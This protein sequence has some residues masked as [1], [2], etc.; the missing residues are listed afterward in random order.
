MDEKKR[1]SHSDS[2]RSQ[3]A[4][5]PTRL[6][7]NVPM[8]S[9][10]APELNGIDANAIESSRNRLS[11]CA[12]R[13][14]YLY[15]NLNFNRL[16]LEQRF[17]KHL[18]RQ[19]STQL[20]YLHV[21]LAIFSAIAILEISGGLAKV[22]ESGK[23]ETYY[24]RLGF[25]LGS[26]AAL[27]AAIVTSRFIP[28]HQGQLTYAILYCVYGCLAAAADVTANDTLDANTSAVF[29][30][31]F[32]VAY[33][34]LGKTFLFKFM[35]STTGIVNVVYI[36]LAPSF[37]NDEHFSITVFQVLSVVITSL[38]LCYSTHRYE[39]RA[40]RSFLVD[41]KAQHD[42]VAD[43]SQTLSHPHSIPPRSRQSLNRRRTYSWRGPIES[44]R[45]YTKS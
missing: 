7:Y 6:L 11:S 16:Q 22:D 30:T 1:P 28:P 18:Q 38:F 14:P 45:T 34:L 10:R 42:K 24:Q 3:S 17:R 37:R 25:T 36:I 2:K 26:F 21:A 5:V 8:T 33:H 31:C 19:F 41:L 44:A 32:L 4:S 39:V 43:I 9:T 29:I 12:R 27:L 40:R 35:S 13:T 15:V 23:Q 20:V